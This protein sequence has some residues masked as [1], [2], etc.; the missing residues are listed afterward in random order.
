MGEGVN[1]W[2][3]GFGGN[4]DYGE[5]LR[6]RHRWVEYMEG[7]LQRGELNVLEEVWLRITKRELKSKQGFIPGSDI[8]VF[9]V[10]RLSPE[11]EGFSYPIDWDPGEDLEYEG[12]SGMLR[13]SW[14]SKYKKHFGTSRISSEDALAIKKLQTNS[15]RIAVRGFYGGKLATGEDSRRSYMKIKGKNRQILSDRAHELQEELYENRSDRK[16]MDYAMKKYLKR[17][18]GLSGGVQFLDMNR[19]Q[20]SPY[21]DSGGHVKNSRLVIKV[22]E[23]HIDQLALDLGAKYKFDGTALNR[24]QLGWLCGMR[25]GHAVIKN[26]RDGVGEISLSTDIQLRYIARYG[27]DF[28][29]TYTVP[30]NIIFGCT[31]YFKRYIAT[32]ATGGMFQDHIQMMCDTLAGLKN[33]RRGYREKGLYVSMARIDRHIDL[34]QLRIKNTKGARTD[35]YIKKHQEYAKVLSIFF[36]FVKNS[37]RF[38]NRNSPMLVAEG[39]MTEKE[40]LKNTNLIIEEHIKREE[41]SRKFSFA[42]SRFTRTER[43]RYWDGNNAVLGYENPSISSYGKEDAGLIVEEFINDHMD[44]YDVVMVRNDTIPGLVKWMVSEYCDNIVDLKKALYAEKMAIRYFRKAR[45]A[46]LLLA[47]LFNF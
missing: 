22:S 32:G 9:G 42:K 35:N 8:P 15:E 45:D 4:V 20:L 34:L 5:W 38:K 6:E 19:I 21:V 24:H 28:D 43:T 23:H 11:Q 39:D 46:G 17:M 44:Y 40:L 27:I 29:I 41:K 13:T 36:P 30:L 31:D 10:Y 16:Q 12:T 25:N 18:E 47:D 1:N 14:Y 2:G 26:I 33:M 37:P 7:R 3:Y